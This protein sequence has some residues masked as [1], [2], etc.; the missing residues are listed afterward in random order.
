VKIVVLEMGFFLKVTGGGKKINSPM[1]RMRR[2]I[3]KETNLN[4]L[5]IKFEILNIHIKN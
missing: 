4:I 5:N 2:K 1:R 3:R